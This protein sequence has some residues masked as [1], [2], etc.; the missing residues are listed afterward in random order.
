MIFYQSIIEQY[1]QRI[2]NFACH[3]TGSL[4]DAEEITQDVLISIWRHWR[5]VDPQRLQAWV[6]RVARNACLSIADPRPTGVNKS[7]DMHPIIK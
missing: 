3:F 6:M 5:S 4:E 2:Y 1:Q 7:I